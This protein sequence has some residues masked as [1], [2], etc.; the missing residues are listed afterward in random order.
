MVTKPLL[1]PRLV[2]S[3]TSQLND[4]AESGTTEKTKQGLKHMKKSR[5][6]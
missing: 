5:E 3:S 4:S 6:E 2:I 1:T